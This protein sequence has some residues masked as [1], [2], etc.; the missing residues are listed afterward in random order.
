MHDISNSNCARGGALRV[1]Y[2]LQHGFMSVSPG[3]ESQWE[4]EISKG[5]WQSLSARAI[6]ALRKRQEVGYSDVTEARRLELYKLSLIDRTRTAVASGRAQRL[7]PR[8]G[9]WM[10]GSC[11]GGW[12]NCPKEHSPAFEAFTES[13]SEGSEVDLGFCQFVR[14]WQEG[15]QG[16]LRLVRP[17]HYSSKPATN[18]ELAESAAGWLDGWRLSC[19][20]D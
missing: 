8:S 18:E 6:F 16:K 13:K 20:R 9:C 17:P 14:G 15:G 1:C 12:I 4:V 10:V 19:V 5:Q 7:R 11:T 3:A 2:A